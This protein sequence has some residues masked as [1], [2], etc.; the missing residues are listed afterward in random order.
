MKD[1]KER[2]LED[3]KKSAAISTAIPVIISIVLFIGSLGA[4][5]L[6][7]CGTG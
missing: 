1:S 2:E 3:R 5:S 7:S 6:R 4:L